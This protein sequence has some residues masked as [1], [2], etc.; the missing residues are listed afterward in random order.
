MKV[1]YFTSMYPAVSH[2]FIRRELK[3]VERQLGEVARFAIRDTPHGVVDP[4]D[5]EENAKTFR[6]SSQ[7][8]RRWARAFVKRGVA[9]PAASLRGLAK[10][11][12]LARHGHRGLVHH[13][14]YFAEALLL[15]DEMAQRGVEHLHVHFGTNPAAVAQ[16]SRAMGGP[17][18]SFTVHG[19][20]EL[21]APLGFCLPSKIADSSFVVA[22]THYCSAQLQR[23]AHRGDWDKIQIVRCGVN[24]DFLERAQPIDPASRVL[25]CVGR[26]APQKGQL[27]LVEA[28]ADAL[29]R[30]AD[31]E[32]VLVGDGE[33]R[34]SIERAVESRG[35]RGKVRITGWVDEAG[36]RKELLAGRA[37]V[38]PSF[39]EGLPV[40]IMEAFAV[41]RPVLSTF[42][43][44]IPELVRPDNGWLVP[45]GSKEALTQ[46]ILTVLDTPVAEL[47]AMAARGRAAVKEQHSVITE[48]TK[49]AALILRGV[50]REPAR[51]PG[52]LPQA[53]AT[54]GIGRH[55]PANATPR[56]SDS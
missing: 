38:L 4:D 32:L 12:H 56:A 48:A 5:I 52:T 1:A 37:L 9:R 31:A 30:G 29:A 18:Y 50:Q 16:I 34:D 13:L 49:L 27:L 24:A 21:D 17:P 26:L 44:G 7:P 2:T 36:V 15:L 47:E 14:A 28:F 25:V 22:I 42:I 54:N 40:V 33:L 51:A 11:L 19:P 46:A 45:A 39:A 43:A 20:D 3:E 8:A 53:V 35:I 23:W 6:L 41:G 10:A 55:L